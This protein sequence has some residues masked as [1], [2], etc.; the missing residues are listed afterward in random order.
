VEEMSENRSSE[1]SSDVL[2]KGAIVFS[3]H[4]SPT[5]EIQSLNDASTPYFFAGEKPVGKRENR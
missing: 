5:R 1:N 3:E 4:N 2:N